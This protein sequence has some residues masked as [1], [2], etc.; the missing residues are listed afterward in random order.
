M[1]EEN[2]KL[3]CDQEAMAA[4]CL[5]LMGII[6]EL[7]AAAQMT[8]ELQNLFETCYEGDAK[9]EVMIFLTNLTTHL[10]RLELFYSK[11]TEF[12]AATAQ[13]LLNDD[14]KMSANME[15]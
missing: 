13:A 5:V 2:K 9:E 15:K 6:G 4:Y 11:I 12:M 1:K 7:E 8:A 14:L 3:V 10:Q